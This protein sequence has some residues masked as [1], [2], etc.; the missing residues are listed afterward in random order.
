MIPV[1]AAID[2]IHYIWRSE[3]PDTVA[4]LE[5]PSGF[6]NNAE[7]LN[8]PLHYVWENRRPLR[9]R[10]SDASSFQEFEFLRQLAEEGF[11]D[12]FAWPLDRDRESRN[13]VSFATRSPQGFPEE[14]LERISQLLAVLALVVDAADA[15]RLSQLAGRDPL[16][17]CA[18]R[19]TFSEY[20]RQ[21]WSTCSRGGMPLSLLL[22][23]I[24]HFKL[25]NDTFGHT[26]GD[27]CIQRVAEAAAKS[28]RRDGDLIARVGG[29]EFGIL[30]PG[31]SRSGAKQIAE[32]VRLQVMTGAWDE[33]FV[34]TSRK[35]TVSVG[36]GTVF[37][38]RDVD[39]SA[40]LSFVDDALYE[41]KNDGR[42][43]TVCSVLPQQMLG[44][45]PRTEPLVQESDH[46]SA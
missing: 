12:Y 31:C 24:D 29:E 6:L 30:L 34:S 20:Y 8:S 14:A 18:N 43:R 35:V 25:V 10:L 36:G 3:E 17:G 2:G 13:I 11:T 32:E 41:A 40:F 15:Q 38:G 26:V 5:R 19:R 16:T 46:S 45:R 7:H 9:A 33:I 28:I 22:F 4:V 1:F 27:R 42:N 21:T 37:P 39:P 23:D 44:V